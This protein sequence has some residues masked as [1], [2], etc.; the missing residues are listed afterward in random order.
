MK[1][2]VRY[3]SGDRY[4]FSFWTCHLLLKYVF[5]VPLVTAKLLV[6]YFDNRRYRLNK[7][8]LLNMLIICAPNHW[9][10]KRDSARTRKKSASLKL[11]LRLCCVFNP[12]RHWLR[13]LRC[14]YL[15]VQGWFYHNLICRQNYIFHGL[16]THRQGKHTEKIHILSL[17]VKVIAY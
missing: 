13:R 2:S 16:F 15:M 9:N 8:F 7:T 5:P 12:H 14:V 4:L 3:K 11:F 10:V 17:I 1:T 6:E